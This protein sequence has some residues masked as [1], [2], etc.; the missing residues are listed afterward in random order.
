MAEGAEDT[1]QQKFEAGVNRA[2]KYGKVFIQGTV[3]SNP[4]DAAKQV[5]TANQN[6]AEWL[7]VL[8]PSLKMTVSSEA[9]AGKKISDL[10]AS[11]SNTPE[12]N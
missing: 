5:K 7:G 3:V 10:L 8:F 12:G 9:S 2:L 11:L 4:Q 1:P 6:E